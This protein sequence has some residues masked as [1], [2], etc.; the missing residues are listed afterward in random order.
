MKQVLLDHSMGKDVYSEYDNGI[1]QPFFAVVASDTDIAREQ[2]FVELV[3]RELQRIV[4]EGL[5]ERRCWQA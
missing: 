4:T 5:I 2:E 1:K 3:D